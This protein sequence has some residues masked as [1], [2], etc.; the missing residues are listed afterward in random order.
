[1]KI[2]FYIVIQKF[3]K[4]RNLINFVNGGSAEF[5]ELYTVSIKYLVSWDNFFFLVF[6]LAV[7][8]QVFGNA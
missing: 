8:F 1:M 3:K 7:L 2:I 6:H 4:H 5:C